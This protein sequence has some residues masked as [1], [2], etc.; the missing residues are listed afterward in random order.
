MYEPECV[1]DWRFVRFGGR[2]TATIKKRD[3]SDF[4]VNFGN[5]ITTVIPVNHPLWIICDYRSERLW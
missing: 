4:F 2:V 3:G 5:G 1:A